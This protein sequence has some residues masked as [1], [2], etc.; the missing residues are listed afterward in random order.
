MLTKREIFDRVKDHLLNQMKPA[1]NGSSC[2]YYN[3]KDQTKCA[4]GAL[5][6]PAYYDACI[7]GQTAWNS[8]VK[9]VLEA[10]GIP[11]GN[12]GIFPMVIDLQAMHDT[13]APELWAAHLDKLEKLHLPETPT[14]EEAPCLP[15][16]K[17]STE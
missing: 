13:K 16:E 4:L 1:T 8:G 2:V 5:I 3:E 9:K 14:K 7:E 11:I 17:S 6:N 10:S 12:P 15:K